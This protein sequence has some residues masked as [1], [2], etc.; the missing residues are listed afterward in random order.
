MR[1]APNRLFQMVSF[2][3]NCILVA[4]FTEHKEAWKQ[5]FLLDW[6]TRC[7]GVNKDRKL[8]N[9][10]LPSCIFVFFWALMNSSGLPRVDPVIQLD[11][12]TDLIELHENKRHFHR[13]EIRC[14]ETQTRCYL[15]TELYLSH[16]PYF[17]TNPKYIVK[18]QVCLYVP[19]NIRTN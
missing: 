8:V 2:Y 11:R 18:L 13:P 5:N 16:S 4:C 19:N 14:N 10:E 7:F 9:C 6:R 3:V 1:S 15:I 17:T 12:K